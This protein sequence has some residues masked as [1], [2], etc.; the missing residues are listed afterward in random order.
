MFER[1]KSML[2]K[3]FIQVLRD[4]RMRF[5]IFVI[6]IFQTIVFGYAVNTDVRNVD[7]AVYDQ[8][9]SRQSRE[10]VARFE[11]SGYF[12]IR[13]YV[14]SEARLRYLLDRGEVKLVIRIDH[15][16]AAKITASSMAPVQLILDG[17]DSN[18][19]GII[20]SYAAKLADAYNTELQGR[21]LR[22]FTGT[23]AP[24][25]QVELRS[26]AWF[27]DNLESRNFYVPAVIANIVFIITMILSSMAVVREKEV[28]TMEQLIVTPIRKSEF[29]LG[30]TLP[31]VIIGF[32]DVAAIT[33]AATL[34]FHVPLRG[35]LLL[36]FVATGLFLMSSLGFGLFISTTSRTQQ[37]ALMSAFFFIFPAM[38]L[39]GF[40]FPIDSM[41]RPVQWLT[42]INPLRYYLVII[43]DTFLKGSG[44]TILWP[45]MLAL[46]LL[47]VT[48]LS[49]AVNRFK[50]SLAS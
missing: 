37:Q 21:Q 2:I 14:A 8:D 1:L 39:S 16:F 40:A 6:P 49:F 28:G 13:E 24:L 38:L 5:V 33:L 42:F 17:S 41:P 35:S 23:N 32:I 15:G 48:I 22:I 3:E 10:L 18:T 34:W 45:E 25:P 36:L 43:R 27:N 4:R 9:N 31:F 26:R 30:K 11:R 19:A 47:G 12:R 46:L 44:I 7:T 29:I 50:K 20:L